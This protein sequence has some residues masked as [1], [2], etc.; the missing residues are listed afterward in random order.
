MNLIM[1][2]YWTT[3]RLVDLFI[4]DWSF[5][6]TDPSNSCYYSYQAF[7]QMNEDNGSF[8]TVLIHC[9]QKKLHLQAQ[10]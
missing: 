9:K 7:G 4:K 8:S 1:S 6:K 10:L 2:E 3:L 5:F